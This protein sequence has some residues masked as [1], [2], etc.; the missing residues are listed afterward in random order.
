MSTTAI[1]IL[2]AVSAETA[3]YISILSFLRKKQD[4]VGMPAPREREE[5]ERLDEE[6]FEHV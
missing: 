1:M 5:P 4:R 6:M 3:L 2:T